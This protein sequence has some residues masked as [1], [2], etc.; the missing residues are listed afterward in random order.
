[1][2]QRTVTFYNVDASVGPGGTNQAED[3]ALVRF[4]LRRIGDAP[5]N[6]VPSLAS[7]PINSMYGPDL[8]AAILD[9]QKEVKRRG[10]NCA[11]DGKVNPAKGIGHGVTSAVTGTQ[12]TIAHMNSTYR[13][14]YAQF[15]DDISKDPKCPSIL[16]AK[17]SLQDNG[18]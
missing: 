5:D 16:A 14:R 6:V 18:Y 3:V 10:G 9:F 2:A 11:T 17:F 1:M 13:R 12:Y 4:F 8:K 15:H 7:L